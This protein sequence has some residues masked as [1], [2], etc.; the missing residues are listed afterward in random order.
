MADRLCADRVDRRRRGK[1][2]RAG[3][4]SGELRAELAAVPPPLALAV[5]RP[6]NWALVP[7]EQ[8][9]ANYSRRVLPRSRDLQPENARV[10]EPIAIAPC[11]STRC[12]PARETCT[13]GSVRRRPGMRYPLLLTTVESGSILAA[14]ASLSHRVRR[15]QCLTGE[16]TAKTQPTLLGQAPRGC[17]LRRTTIERT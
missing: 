8:D 3:K 15:L 1:D 14:L 5:V 13:P 6:A 12:C 2:Q 16:G 17:K 7:A 9:P 4:E 11:S 10:A